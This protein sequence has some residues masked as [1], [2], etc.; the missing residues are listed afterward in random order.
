MDSI[1]IPIEETKC[2]CARIVADGA[3]V[4]WRLFGGLFVEVVGY[5]FGCEL[6]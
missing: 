6:K 3:Y 1:Q 5:G 4:W 2:Y